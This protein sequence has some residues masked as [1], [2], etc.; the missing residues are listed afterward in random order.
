[1]Y[2]GHSVLVFVGSTT[3]GASSE[4]PGPAAIGL[5]A[6]AQALFELDGV[7]LVRRVYNRVS[8]PRLGVL[9]PDSALQ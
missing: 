6:L 5:T 1:L 7:A 9:T 4:S 8:A 2:V 3:S